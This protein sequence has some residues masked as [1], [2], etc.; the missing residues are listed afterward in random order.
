[1]DAKNISEGITDDDRAIVR[2]RILA[3]RLQVV[4][5]VGDLK[6]W[7][8]ERG[9]I[10]LDSEGMRN[11]C[12]TLAIYKAAGTDVMITEWGY[13]LP[14]WCRATGRAPHP[15]EREAFARSWARLLKYLRQDQGFTN[16]RYIAIYNEPNGRGISFEDYADV[17]RAI[18]RA[19]REAGIRRDVAILG[20]D[21][22]GAFS[23]F[24]RAV[25]EL[26]DVIDIYDAH[27]Y[28]ANTGEEFA[29]WTKPRVDILP[30]LRT[31][32]S[33][34]NKR[35]ALMICEFGMNRG[36]STY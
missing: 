11:L 34:G 24:E 13:V 31:P 1:M 15:D 26:D 33:Y 32:D 12:N 6:W 10:T 3:M 16:V 4:R 29:L 28:T 20:P 23:W 30:A 25:R 17:Y 22:T 9:K 5:L 14:A 35:K 27:N 2:Q 7:E 21:E 8:P 36:A 19:L 18:D